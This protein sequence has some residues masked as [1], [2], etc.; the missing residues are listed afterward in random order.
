MWQ[1]DFTY[2]RLT[3][4]DGTPGADAEILCF[5]DDHSR[6]AVSVTCHQPVT[7]PVVVAVF[8]QAVADQSIPASVLSDI[9]AWWCPEGPRIVRPAM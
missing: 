6:Y 9:Q 4:P 3:R 8:R 7:G 5:L 2:Y 1:V